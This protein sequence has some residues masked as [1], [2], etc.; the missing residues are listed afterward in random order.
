MQ[1]PAAISP[2]TLAG[3]MSRYKCLSGPVTSTRQVHCH[4][5]TWDPWSVQVT[6]V[7]LTR[8]GKRTTWHLPEFPQ[9]WSGKLRNGPNGGQLASN[10]KENLLKE[11]RLQ[12]PLFSSDSASSCCKLGTRL[13][14]GCRCNG[15]L[16]GGFSSFLSFCG[17]FCGAGWIGAAVKMPLHVPTSSQ[18]LVLRDQLKTDC[19]QEL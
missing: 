18:K 9:C 2:R 11:S 12:G 4:P 6:G 5:P 17:F 1:S 7:E 8:S 16:A 14:R 13:R 3:F 19:E 10:A 15:V